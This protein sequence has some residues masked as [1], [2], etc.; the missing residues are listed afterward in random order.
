MILESEDILNEMVDYLIKEIGLPSIHKR[1]NIY[2][3]DDS[4]QIEVLDNR[5]FF[6]GSAQSKQVVIKNKNLKHFFEHI[7]SQNSK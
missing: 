4:V 7:Q 2:S 6:K 1:L 3:G 5:V